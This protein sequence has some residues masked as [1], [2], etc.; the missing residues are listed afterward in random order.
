MDAQF[1]KEGTMKTHFALPLAFTKAKARTLCV[2]LVPRVCEYA[3]RIS[4]K[5]VSS[6]GLVLDAV[7]VQI[8]SLLL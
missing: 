5:L 7:T 3:C 8:P 4:M 1:K 2:R 6:T